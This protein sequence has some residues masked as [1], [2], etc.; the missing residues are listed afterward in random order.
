MRLANIRA[1]YLSVQ[2]IQNPQNV[3]LVHKVQRKAH[4]Y[5]YTDEPSACNDAKT[6]LRC[7]LVPMLQSTG[8]LSDEVHV[9]G[10]VSTPRRR[11]RIGVPSATTTTALVLVPAAGQTTWPHAMHPTVALLL[12]KAACAQ[13]ERCTCSSSL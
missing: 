8:Q 11:G 1:C 9:T 10:G 13:A 12:S 3:K 4:A 7:L 6:N 2:T 5:T